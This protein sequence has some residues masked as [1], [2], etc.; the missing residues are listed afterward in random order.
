MVT[1]AAS[2]LEGVASPASSP[3]R[4]AQ[5]QA[6]RRRSQ[7]IRRAR[8][9][10][11]ATI[12]AVLVLLT[13]WVLVK[14]LLNRIIDGHAG[15]AVIHMTNAHFYGR[16]GNG[17]AFMLAAAEASRSNGDVQQFSLVKPMLQFNADLLKPS[18]ITANRGAYREDTHIL[19]LSDHVVLIDGDGDRFET[20]QAYIDTVRAEVNGWSRVR[21]S[22]PHGVITADAYG[23]YDHGQRVV[24]RGNVHS[25]LKQ[26]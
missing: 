1:P 12:A 6:W 25:I 22:G 21:G 14:S 5:M 13:G 23:V 10:L 11:P 8:R 2:E 4:R 19:V 3:R 24:F 9:V 16:D 17:R 18:Q 26:D 20:D 15:G 7:L